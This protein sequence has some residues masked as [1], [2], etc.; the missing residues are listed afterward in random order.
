MMMNMARN[1]GFSL[2]ELLVALTVF[3]VGLMALA[4]M[5]FTSIQGNSTANQLTAMTAL[6]DGLV[7]ELLVKAQDDPVFAANVNNPWPVDFAEPDIPM[8]WSLDGTGLCTAEYA[9]LINDPINGVAR[10][11]VTVEAQDRSVTKTAIKRI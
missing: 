8:E 4:G 2:V 1:D 5:Q 6:A 3:S 10:I 11:T 7:E 9:V